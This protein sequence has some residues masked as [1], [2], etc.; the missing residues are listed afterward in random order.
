MADEDEAL[1]LLGFLNTPLFRSGLNTYCGQH[2]TSGYVNLFPF[3]ELPRDVVASAIL[4]LAVRKRLAVERA[5]E[6]DRRFVTMPVAETLAVAY[7][8]LADRVRSAAEA[9][10]RSEEAW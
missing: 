9:T 5:C 8:A 1:R 7:E 6:T 4:E 3:R 10:V 2:K